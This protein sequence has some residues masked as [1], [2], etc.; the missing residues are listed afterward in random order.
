MK[1]NII[2]SLLCKI[3]S[4]INLNTIVRIINCTI[5]AVNFKILIVI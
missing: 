2:D 4:N 1:N 3:W 5:G